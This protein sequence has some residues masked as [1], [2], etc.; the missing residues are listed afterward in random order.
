MST[1]HNDP[2]KQ[3]LFLEKQ[4]GKLRVREGR[5][6]SQ[7]YKDSQRASEQMVYPA[8]PHPPQL[9]CPRTASIL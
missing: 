4:M 8:L 2:V 6:V 9:S 7:C 1:V 3:A 5:G